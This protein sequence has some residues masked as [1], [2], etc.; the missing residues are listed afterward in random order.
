MN[1]FGTAISLAD[2]AFAEAETFLNVLTV[3]PDSVDV[4]NGDYT[5]VSLL[6]VPTDTASDA[7]VDLFL[8]CVAVGNLAVDW[9]R[10]RP[11]LLRLTEP[12]LAG[13]AP[14]LDRRGQAMIS[15]PFGTY[16]TRTYRRTMAA[17]AIAGKTTVAPAGREPRRNWRGARLAS[18]S[19]PQR[20]DGGPNFIVRSQEGGL[21]FVI[22]RQEGQLQLSLSEPPLEYR[23]RT[24]EV[25]ISVPGGVALLLPEV[26]AG[27]KP[28]PVPHDLTADQQ[29]EI[30]YRLL[31]FPADSQET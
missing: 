9:T 2:C 21:E 12:G 8:S 7:Q 6:S 13:L 10:L 29:Y 15:L 5:Q 24:L 4:R 22:C 16:R 25:I 3:E 1:T 27:G 18:G 11:G 20:D 28:V 30:V 31:P 19:A 17:S 23:G 14:A 26:V